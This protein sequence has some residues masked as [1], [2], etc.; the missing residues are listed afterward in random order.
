MFMRKGII[1]LIS[2]PCWRASVWP[3]APSR[4][5]TTDATLEHVVLSLDWVPNT[6]HT[7]FYVALDKGWY[8]AE[9][10]STWRSDPVGRRR[11]PQAGGCRQYPVRCQ[12]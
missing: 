5:R 12:L 8:A 9:R 6:N 3:A 1:V 2:W 4:K 11:G 10:A 7:G